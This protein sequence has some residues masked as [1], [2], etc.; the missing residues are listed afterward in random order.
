M[1]G[2]ILRHALT[3][4]PVNKD[5]GRLRPLRKTDQEEHHFTHK[6]SILFNNYSNVIFNI[7]PAEAPAKPKFET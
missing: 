6:Y 3:K 1:P 2:E 5:V 4:K 7:C